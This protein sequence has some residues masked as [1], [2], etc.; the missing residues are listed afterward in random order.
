MLIKVAIAG[1]AGRMGRTLA[2]MV[3]AADDLELVGGLARAGSPFLGQYRGW[4]VP[5]F[6]KKQNR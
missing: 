2:E 5:A 1:I 4:V 3:H 6:R